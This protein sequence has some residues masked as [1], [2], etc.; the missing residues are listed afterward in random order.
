MTS[1]LFGLNLLVIQIDGIHMD[2]NLILVAIDEIVTV[3]RLGLPKE[4]RRSLACCSPSRIRH[5]EPTGS[6]RATP[7]LLFQH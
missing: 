4:L 7:A 6:R 3:T 5:P 2:E 1:D